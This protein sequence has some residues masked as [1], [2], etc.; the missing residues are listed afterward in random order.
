[1]RIPINQTMTRSPLQVPNNPS[2][3]PYSKTEITPAPNPKKRRAEANA[4]L[5]AWGDA[6][7]EC[8]YPSS[9]EI[10]ELATK[11]GLTEDQVSFW[12]VNARR[13]YA[14]EWGWKVD[15]LSTQNERNLRKENSRRTHPSASL[16]KPSAKRAKTLPPSSS[17]QRLPPPKFGDLRAELLTTLALCCCVVERLPYK[18]AHATT[19]RPSV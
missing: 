1:M 17:S 18:F 3:W 19:F 10:R 15:R 2:Q 16:T 14:E 12:F 11:T 8:P 5:K 13:R 4:V 7:R 6:H 9:G